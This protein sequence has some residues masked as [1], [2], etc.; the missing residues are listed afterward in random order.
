MSRGAKII[1]LIIIG[2]IAIGLI[3][4]FIILPLF[5]RSAPSA[6]DANTNI[7]ASL[8]AANANANKNA[9][10]NAPLPAAVLPEVQLV[11]SAR[12]VART[13]AERLDTYTNRNGLSNLADL[14]TISTPAAWKYLDDE[15]RTAL[16]AAMPVGKD[17]YGVVSTAMN[18]NVALDSSGG[19]D[20][21]VGLQRVESGA[22]SKTSY[23]TLDLKLKKVG[24]E[25]L[26]SWLDWEK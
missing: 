20:A 21:K 10:V 24:D 17:Y 9:N 22:V 25:W 19:I 2:V 5:P 15:Y 1:I 4:Y 23:P 16:I 7:N 18:V 6:S 26:V 13:F 8:P 3:F 14:K 12:S 11:S